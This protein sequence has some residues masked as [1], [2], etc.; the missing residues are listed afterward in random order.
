MDVTSYIGMQ[1][2]AA[3]NHA[4]R[5]NLIFRA[6]TVDG[7]PLLGLPQDI[8]EDRVCVEIVA[9]KVSKAWIG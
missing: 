2:R 3:Q 7:E 5:M 4:E 1:K 9:D 8:R 6:V